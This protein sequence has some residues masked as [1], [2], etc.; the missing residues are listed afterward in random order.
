MGQMTGERGRKGAS[1]AVSGSRALT[2]GLKDFL[3]NPARGGEAQQVDSF[4]KIAASDNYVRRS[5][6]M[7]STSSLAHGI[8]RCSQGHSAGGSR[9]GGRGAGTRHQRDAGDGSGFVQIWG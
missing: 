4:I 3:L 6:N 9:R 1:R 8:H 7:Q 5:E 2:F